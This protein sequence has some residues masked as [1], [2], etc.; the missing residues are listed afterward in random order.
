MSR[1]RKRR[2]ASVKP[3]AAKPAPAIAG[4][5]KL[6]P[7]KPVAILALAGML[8]TGYLAGAA[9]VTDNPPLCSADSGCGIIHESPFSML[10]GLPL[11]LWGFGFYAAVLWTAATLPPRPRRWQRLTWLAGIGLAISIYLTLTGWL[12]LDAWCGWCMASLAAVMLMF[13]WLLARRRESGAA[14]PVFGRS[15]LLSAAFVTV[16]LGAWQHGLLQPPENSELRL[17]AE[18]LDKSGAMYFGAYWCPECQRQRR[19][20][21]RSAHRLPYVECTPGGRSGMVAFE[22]LSADISA[23]PTWIIDGRRFQQ[24]LTPEELSRFSGFDDRRRERDES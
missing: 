9:L 21:G 10:L 19:L 18:H 23:Y 7:D 17:L 16:L 3:A 12:K 14:G 1:K 5:K 13:G 22:C 6:H 15:L 8:I 20:F 2:T 24:V 4:G 11:S